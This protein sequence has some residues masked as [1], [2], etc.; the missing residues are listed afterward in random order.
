MPRRMLGVMAAVVLALGL[1]ACDDTTETPN[2]VTPTTPTYVDKTE[3]FT[4]TVTASETK[5]H[6]FAVQPGRVTATL[7]TLAPESTTP[8]GVNLGTFDGLSCNPVVANATAVQGNSLVGTASSATTLCL[9]VYDVGNL[10]DKTQNYTVT[11]VYKV[12]GS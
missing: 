10:T 5:S 12:T 8:V 6:F 4:G 3:T 2:P 9:Q 7:T 11:V 1:A